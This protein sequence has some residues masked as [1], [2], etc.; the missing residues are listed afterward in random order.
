MLSSV[1]SLPAGLFSA[2]TQSEEAFSTKSAFMVPQLL[3]ALFCAR[4]CHHLCFCPSVYSQSPPLDHR[5]QQDTLA[6]L[7]V[8]GSM[9]FAHFCSMSPC[10]LGPWAD[11][12][13]GRGSYQ[14]SGREGEAW[15]FILGCSGAPLQGICVSVLWCPKCHQWGDLTGRSGAL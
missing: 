3:P 2:P 10:V 4:H 8:F 9:S 7:S 6:L 14:W 15:R 11:V 13:L 1:P 12:S 5:L